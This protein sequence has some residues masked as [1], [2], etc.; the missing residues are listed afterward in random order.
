MY[1]SNADYTNANVGFLSA[2]QVSEHLQQ[3]D[4]ACSTTSC[5][6]PLSYQSSEDRGPCPTEQQPHSTE[7]L[8][9]LSELK[10]SELH[11]YEC[12]NNEAT[13][14]INSSTINYF[15]MKQIFEFKPDYINKYVN[16][17]FFNISA[18][19]EILKHRR[20]KENPFPSINWEKETNDSTKH[21]VVQPF[22]VL[23]ATTQDDKVIRRKLLKSNFIL[24]QELLVKIPH[25]SKFFFLG[26]FYFVSSSGFDAYTL[27]NFSDV[28]LNLRSVLLRQKFTHGQKHFI[29]CQIIEGLSVLHA[30]DI[31]HASLNLGNI[32]LTHPNVVKIGYFDNSFLQ[33]LNKNVKNFVHQFP[34]TGPD[35]FNAAT[36]PIQT[37]L[38]IWS[39]GTLF[40]ELMFDKQ[41]CPYHNVSETLVNLKPGNQNSTEN[42]QV[43]LQQ[44]ELYSNVED[45]LEKLHEEKLRD[46]SAATGSSKHKNAA[47]VAALADLFIKGTLQ[48]QPEKRLTI[49]QLK[50]N[51]LFNTYVNRELLKKN[52]A[53]KK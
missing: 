36:Q 21:Y 5:S 6:S 7:D 52:S 38:D 35:L 25:A 12:Y 27:Y 37:S 45:Y 46:N 42:Q 40:L 26:L 18:M 48:L 32:F 20:L 8:S 31:V 15:G 4:G 53:A 2:A 22:G 17:Y 49:S 13:P 47:E 16:K 14:T 41:M 24:E 9:L 39:L 43:L 29:V 34:H 11:S 19:K 3:H 51:P 33:S 10:T 1:T 50:L 44:K 30:N 23:N 28:I